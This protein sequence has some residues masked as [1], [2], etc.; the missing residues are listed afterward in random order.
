MAVN[1]YHFPYFSCFLS[2]NKTNAPKGFLFLSR[3]VTLKRFQSRNI[4]KFAGTM[5][6]N[7]CTLCATNRYSQVYFL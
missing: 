5:G 2:Q 7:D 1:C 6:M 4:R 3:N